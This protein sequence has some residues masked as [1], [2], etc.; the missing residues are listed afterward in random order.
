M[1]VTSR[2]NVHSDGQLM[3]SLSTAFGVCG[4]LSIAELTSLATLC[5]ML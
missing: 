2:A 1:C 5:V 3:W 4:L